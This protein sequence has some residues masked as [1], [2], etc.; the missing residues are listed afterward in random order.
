MTS[1]AERYARSQRSANRGDASDFDQFLLDQSFGLDKFQL[2]AI[3]AVGSN[4]S[5]LVAAPTGS[6]KTKIA[7]YALFRSLREKK[8]AFYTTPI[9]ALSNQKYKEFCQMFG[10]N[11]VGLLTG[12]R[13]IN[14]E[15]SIVVMTTEVL[16][17]MI[18]ANS[19]NLVNLLWVVM[20]E[21]HYLADKNR[22][23]VW[24]ETMILLPPEV[25]LVC[26]SATVSN[27]EEFG[28]W[29]TDI[30]GD[31]EVI[32]EE[33]R[34]TPLWQLVYQDHQLQDL[35]KD[36]TN[37]KSRELNPAISRSGN[38]QK[39]NKFE[40]KNRYQRPGGN[41]NAKALRSEIVAA[42]DHAG[43]LPA[44]Y[45][46]FS[47][48]GCAEAVNNLQS[49]NLRLLNTADRKLVLDRVDEACSIIPDGDLQAVDFTTWREGLARG[50]AAHH[51]GMLPIF[52]EVVEDLFQ[53]GLLKVVFATE[54]LALGIN[55]P[56]KTVVIESLRKFNGETHVDLTAGEYTQLTGRAGRRG[57]DHEGYAVIPIDDSVNPESVAGLAS[58]RTYPLNSSFRPSYNMSLNLLQRF[59][60]DHS[61]TLLES[62][63]A[64][65]QADQQVVGLAAQ[66]KRIR[67]EAEVQKQSLGKDSGLILDYLAMRRDIRRKEDDLH[68]DDRRRFLLD[69]DTACRALQIGD[70]VQIKG[71][72]RGFL[73]VVDVDVNRMDLSVISEKR[74]FQKLR[75]SE[76][77]G[78]PLSRGFV[79]ISRGFNPRDAFARKKLLSQIDPATFTLDH[80][81]S[82]IR[83]PDLSLVKLKERLRAHPVHGIADRETYIRAAE[84]SLKMLDDAEKLEIRVSNRTGSLGRQFKQICVLLR[85]NEYLFGDDLK[86]TSKGK[87]LSRMYA[88][89]DLLLAEAIDA[90]LLSNLS[91]SQFGALLSCFVYESRD[92]ID[93]Y[94]YKYPDK[95]IST[96]VVAI[97][98]I[99]S[100]IHRQ[101][102][103][104]KIPLTRDLNPGFSHAIGSWINGANL[105]QV[106]F[107]SD[108]QPGDFVRWCRQVI[109][110]ASQLVHD[111]VPKQVKD[112]ARKVIDETMKGVV[113][114]YEAD[115]TNL[116]DL[117]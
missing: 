7:E 59:G 79:R 50:F 81:V 112:N 114:I 46:I 108:L 23:A 17:N 40:S 5:V 12:D 93:I 20:D 89:A 84:R 13:S 56:A 37:L 75:W 111:T 3:D 116:E 21:V 72:Q 74:G 55:M 6:G 80:T 22:G 86:L 66:A 25:N 36:P 76:L 29:I 64:Q 42:L 19:T 47:R 115:L 35:F 71:G 8:R 67:R 44:L 24:E 31:V 105:D 70:V 94:R 103:Q 62:S 69:V 65:Y 77:P 16:R 33:K 117:N 60:L 113:A 49:S 14:I 106:L 4:R 11:E 110:I 30:R 102:K 99:L 38:S 91:T 97:N 39:R 88:E 107:E 57:I 41:R 10:S 100:E 28:A 87:L 34:P 61:V 45:F 2:D 18:Y 85:E 53:R 104:N 48:K 63:F 9:K 68:N 83:E 52:K 73:I 51:A 1:P 82:E 92:E 78:T 90:D 109:D 43:Q 32:L 95:L 98:N 54:T 58:T 27:A 26:L 96:R 101:E 15:A